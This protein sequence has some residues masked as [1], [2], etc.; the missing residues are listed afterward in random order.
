MTGVVRAGACCGFCSLL[1]VAACFAAAESDAAKSLAGD[2]ETLK[3]VKTL[4]ARF[5]CEKNL[6]ALETPLHSEGRV[7]IQK[8]ENGKEGSVRF[9]TEKPYVS[10][11]ILTDGKVFARSQHETEW[12]KTNQSSRPGLTAVMSQLGGWSTGG[13]AKIVE[14]YSVSRGDA[15]PAMPGAES[16]SPQDVDVFVLTPT[17]KDLV[18]AVKQV[19]IA[20][21]RGLH[22]LRYVEIVTQQGDST[23]YWFYDVHT[24]VTLPADVFKADGELVLPEERKP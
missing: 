10:E 21:D 8:G 20:I 22:T 16:G 13:T 24:D 7:W 12:S 6:A 3:G 15:V 11:L 18:K 14:M 19:T 9:S 1:F 17:N 2:W 4:E 5:V 23:R